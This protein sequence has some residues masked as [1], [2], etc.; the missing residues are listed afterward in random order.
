MTRTAGA[1]TGGIAALGFL[2]LGAS[3]ALPVLVGLLAV[4]LSLD[5]D[6]D[7][8]R[9]GLAIS[10]FWLVTAFSA[11]LGGRWVDRRGWPA[12]ATGGAVVV[13]ACLLGC[14]LLVDRWASLLVVLA[15]GGLGYALCSPTSNVAVVTVVPAARRASVLGLKQ[16]APPLLAG[17][18]AATLPL[19]AQAHGWRVAMAAGL[20]LPAAVLA[21]VPAL[22]AA[23]APAHRRRPGTGPSAV[24]VGGPAPAAPPARR[25]L[26]LVAAAGLGTLSV[27]TVTG[28]SVLTLVSVGLEPVAAGAV[29]SVGSL[30]AVLARVGS[31]AFLDR[32]P[33]DD[34]GPLLAL[35]ALAALSLGAVGVGL[36][37]AEQAG[38]SAWSPWSVV[39]VGG[40]VLSLVSAW[41][42]PALLLLAVVRTAAAPG[43]ASGRLQVGSGL[44][45]A[46]GPVCF[47]LLSTTGGRG[48]AWLLMAM[49]TLLAVALVHRAGGRG[50]RT[51]PAAVRSSGG[52]GV[53]G[54]IPAG[55]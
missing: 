41:T 23:G 14:V 47:G 38:A 17:L 29:V 44:G 42:W 26:M 18:L 12:G 5:L 16:T 13:A 34:D 50:R 21:L 37:G 11:P 2:L 55:Y 33:V 4:D 27:A 8:R 36:V 40:V 3:T 28:F 9:L 30:L 1:P 43:A 25:E 7:D 15:L 45:S 51:G 35:M 54:D 19:V 48:P 24:P 53:E 32:R 49:C 22:L 52:A 6:L 39:V 20:V 10:A 31:G 46:V